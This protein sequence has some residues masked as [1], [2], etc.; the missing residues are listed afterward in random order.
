MENIMAFAFVRRYLRTRSV[1]WNV[2][3]EL[4]AYSDRDLHDIGIDRADISHIAKAA[5]QEA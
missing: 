1:Y 5:A 3:R 4:S 2:V